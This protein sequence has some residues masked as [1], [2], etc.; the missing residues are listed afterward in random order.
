[1]ADPKRELLRHIVATVAYRGAKALRG[2][3]ESFASFRAS[4]SSRTPAQILAHM[5]DLF[6]WVLSIAQG[7]Q[8]WKDSTPLPWTAEC[9]RFFNALAALDASLASDA[10]IAAPIE[11]IF[12]G[13][14][15][16]AL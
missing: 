12:Q 8:A 14:I 1:M 5:G 6:D 2:A 13:G 11:K 3:P 10:P 7:K 4:D 16:D 9:A 15:A